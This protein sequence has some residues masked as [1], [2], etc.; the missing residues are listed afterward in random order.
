M[1]FRQIV[2]E[3]FLQVALSPLPVME[4]NSFT[5]V[6]TQVASGTAATIA[7]AKLVKSLLLDDKTVSLQ[8]ID[9]VVGHDIGIAV[10]E[11]EPGLPAIEALH[12]AIR[13]IDG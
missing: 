3:V 8:L 6:L 2:D 9:P 7:P 10:L 5:A 12:E 1:H 11:N 4:S 13:T